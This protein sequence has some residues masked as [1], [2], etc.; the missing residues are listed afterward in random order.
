MFGLF[1]GPAVNGKCPSS[2]SSSSELSGSMDCHHMEHHCHLSCYLYFHQ[3]CYLCFNFRSIGF[4]SQFKSL[5]GE[6]SSIAMLS[7][8]FEIFIPSPAPVMLKSMV[9]SNS[10]TSLLC[11]TGML[12]SLP[13]K[14]RPYKYQIKGNI[15]FDWKEIRMITYIHSWQTEIWN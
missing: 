13:L 15:S 7:G 4:H 9:S 5:F 14:V 3:D 12:F 2:E 11:L 8:W 10:S 6:E 1:L